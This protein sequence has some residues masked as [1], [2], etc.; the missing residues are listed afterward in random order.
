LPLKN[1][2][3]TADTP[4]LAYG[5]II[6]FWG[7]SGSLGIVLP[8]ARL[9]AT[10]D[11]FEQQTRVERNG[12][13]DL[14]LRLSINLYGA[15][16]L[17]LRDFSDYHQNIII[18]A[19]FQVTAPSGSYMPSKLV[20]IGTNRWS[21]KSEVGVSKAVAPWTFE[22]AA[23]VTFFTD[24]DDYLGGNVRHQ[25][26]LLSVQGHA[27]YNF[28]RKM[29]AALD[30]TYYAG[31]RTSLNGS[32]DNDLQ[33]NSRWGGT[34]AYTITAHD[35]VKLYFSSGVT[36]RT[37]TDFRIYGIAWQYRWGAGLRP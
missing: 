34:Y 7:Q 32:L 21:F 5:R 36:A 20:N 23:G 8:Y 2:H 27:I 14:S 25:D 24:N 6:D 26:A 31:G 35:S 4:F 15:A 28:N 22:A 16:A 12:L 30:L 10:A 33:S 13:S 19:S 29:W 18:G 17:S 11:V 9:S 37:G 3:A 1:V